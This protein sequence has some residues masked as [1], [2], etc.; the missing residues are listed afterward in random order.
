M[1]LNITGILTKLYQL[2]EKFALECEA[3]HWC[4]AAM[5]YEMAVLVSRFIEM[6]RDSRE[7]LLNQ[8]QPEVVEQVYK[9]AG[10][11]EEVS[12]ADRKADRKEA[13]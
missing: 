11:Y 4:A 5:A 12:D 2:P 1:M 13:V 10:W 8:F 6:D 3:E 7:K 9:N